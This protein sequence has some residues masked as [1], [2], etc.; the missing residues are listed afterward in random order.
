MA[1]DDPPE[2]MTG[3]WPAVRYRR[4]PE[5]MPDLRCGAREGLW[6]LPS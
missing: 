1:S 6:T 2:A 3:K 5:D 4:L